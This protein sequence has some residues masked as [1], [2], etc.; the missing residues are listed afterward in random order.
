MQR[1]VI[2]GLLIFV[3][4]VLPLLAACGGETTPAPTATTPVPTATTPQPTATTPQPTA[5]AP[6]ATTPK[7]TAQ[8]NWWD[9]FGEPQ[10]GGTITVPVTNLEYTF[11]PNNWM[12]CMWWNFWHEALWFPDWTLD[13]KVFSFFSDWT[14]DEYWKGLLAESWEWPDAQTLV[15]HLRQG[16][17]W[18]NK[19]PAN[20]R[21]F[22]ADDVVY[23]LNRNME[24]PYFAGR[25]A[26]IKS[27]TSTDK[28][29]VVFNFNNPAPV[30]NFWAI[31]PEPILQCFANREAVDLYGDLKEWTHAVG[32]GSFILTD[33]QPGTSMTM[34][35]NPDYWGY[36]ERHPQNQL[37]YA[38]AI[39]LLCIADVPTQ[40][41]ALRTGKLDRMENVSW[42]QAQS[43]TRTSPDLQQKMTGQPGRLLRLRNDKAPFTDI[44]VRKALEMAIDRPTIAKTYYGGTVDWRPVGVIN[45][46]FIGYCTPYDEWPQSL[47]DEYTYNPTKAKQLLADSGYPNGFKTNIVAS[48]D[49]DLQLLQILKAELLDIGVDM[50]IRVM[51][52][53]SL[54]AFVNAGK[55]DQMSY[56]GLSD[57][58]PPVMSIQMWTSSNPTNA[59][60]NNDPAYD[61]LVDS[62]RASAN[63]DEA[64]QR[65]IE[66]DMYY[67]TH[68]W[69]IP[70]FSI[71]NYVVWQSYLK[72]Y[73]GE[74][75]LWGSGPHYARWWIDQD[76]KKSMGR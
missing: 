59:S 14:P 46:N 18:Q 55:H 41:A 29:T 21:E 35:R 67:L 56:S 76:V 61:A 39:R 45:P 15:V 72:G 62:V 3:L 54:R 51:D 57:M 31:V 19:E 16:V 30:T 74:K 22:V 71:G 36:D 42:Q 68:H 2:F 10:Y 58:M 1:K 49:D 20:G 23:G 26:A 27:V 75:L 47:K 28:Y 52:P 40:M 33:Y 69:N 9:K 66:T 64:K 13:R 5:T 48:S 44:N 43:L 25:Y 63:L 73:S 8:A 34:S 24:S 4:F 12:G 7:P 50:E 17:H 32:T 38:D 37:P 70:T 6:T 60:Y 53:M 65:L 11:D